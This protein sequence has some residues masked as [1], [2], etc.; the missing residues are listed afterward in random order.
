MKKLVDA[1]DTEIQKWEKDLEHLK[2]KVEAYE[3]HIAKLKELRN[4]VDA[5]AVFPE[6]HRIR[7]GRPK[8]NV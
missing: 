5:D 3:A 1:F 6:E 4:Q 2:L 7:R 8:K